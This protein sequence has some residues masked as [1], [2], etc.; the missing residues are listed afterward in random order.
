MRKPAEREFNKDVVLAK[1]FECLTMK[2]IEA[3]AIKDFSE[4]TGMAASSIYYWFEDKDEIVL[5][6]VKWGLMRM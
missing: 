2:G 3:T 6:A 1:C 5:D 4:A